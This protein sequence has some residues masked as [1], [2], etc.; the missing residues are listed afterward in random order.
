MSVSRRC[1]VIGPRNRTA[2]DFRDCELDSIAGNRAF[3]VDRTAE[4]RQEM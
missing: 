4:E 2:T 1:V 3:Q